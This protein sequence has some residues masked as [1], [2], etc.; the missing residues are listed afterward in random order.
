MTDLQ[1]VV[2]LALATSAISVTISRG[3]VFSR[4]RKWLLKNKNWLGRLASCPYCTSHWVAAVLVAIYQPTLLSM[5]RPLDLAISVFI[6]LAMGAV[7]TGIITRL[8]PFEAEGEEL[9]ELYEA[10]GRAKVTISKL[11]RR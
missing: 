4:Q 6:V 11:T 8:I 3:G 9:D 5:W 2:A 10:L 7:I 1:Q